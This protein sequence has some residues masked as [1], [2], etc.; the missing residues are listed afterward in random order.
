[1]SSNIFGRRADIRTQA[2][3]F[4]QLLKELGWVLRYICSSLSGPQ[5]PHRTSQKLLCFLN[6]N[7]TLPIY[8]QPSMTQLPWLY[9]WNSQDAHIG[10]LKIYPVLPFLDNTELNKFCNNNCFILL[11]QILKICPTHI[12]VEKYVYI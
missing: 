7:K 8:E 4:S 9:S 1:M 5:T 12:N 2:A 10:N 3:S 6:D 11:K